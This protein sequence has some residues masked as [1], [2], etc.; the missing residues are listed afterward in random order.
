VV[1]VERDGSG[2]HVKAVRQGFLVALRR[3][4]ARAVGDGTAR[5]DVG[6][7]GTGEAPVVWETTQVKTLETTRGTIDVGG[8]GEVRV[9]A[10][11][12]PPAVAEEGKRGHRCRAHEDGSGGFAV[13]CQTGAIAAARHVS[14]DAP[15]DGLTMVREGTFVRLDLPAPVGRPEAFAIAYV[16]GFSRVVIRAEASMVA[17]EAKPSLALV[18]AARVQPMPMPVFRH[19]HHMRPDIM[20]F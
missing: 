18:S 5:L 14:S 15:Q 17:G 1:R 12:V 6:T 16:D 11:G 20:D 8:G 2:L 10:V 13:V 9:A 19:H 3:A 7:G 4:G